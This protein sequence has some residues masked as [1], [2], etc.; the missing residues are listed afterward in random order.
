MKRSCSTLPGWFSPLS[1][2]RHC[3]RRGTVVLAL[4]VSTCTPPTSPSTRQMPLPFGQDGVAAR[5]VVLASGNYWLQ[6]YG[7]VASSNPNEPVCMPVERLPQGGSSLTVPVQLT[8]DGS[9]WAA[10]SPPGLG[11]LMLR[12]QPSDRA[13]PQGQ[14]VSGSIRGLGYDTPADHRPSSLRVTIGGP[15]DGAELR[16][17]AATGPFLY[18]DITGPAVI[19][20]EMGSVTCSLL[21]WTLQ[22]ERRLR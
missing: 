13:L 16:G 3:G 18:G 22:P 15:T 6:I 1:S 2:C 10:A 12:F 11:D 17:I 9:G 7:F 8:G 4:A 20:D 19:D 14:P 5:Q 21:H